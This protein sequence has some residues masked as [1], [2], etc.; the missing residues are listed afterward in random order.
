MDSSNPL[1]RR[2]YRSLCRWG[3]KTTISYQTPYAGGPTPLF[4]SPQ[5]RFFIAFTV[6]NLLVFTVLIITYIVQFKILDSGIEQCIAI[7]AVYIT[8][9]IFAAINTLWYIYLSRITSASDQEWSK[10]MILMSADIILQLVT[11]VVTMTVSVQQF[12]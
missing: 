6:V 11:V 1:V 4:R 8:V 9:I 5:R 12:K 3:K 2:C 10:Y 7:D